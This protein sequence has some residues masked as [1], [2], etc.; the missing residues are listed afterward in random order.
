[1][2]SAQHEIL[3]CSGSAG[4]RHECQRRFAQQ[5]SSRNS[6]PTGHVRWQTCDR[7]LPWWPVND[8]CAGRFSDA[9]PC[10]RN[11]LATHCLQPKCLGTKMVWSRSCD[12]CGS[13]AL[14]HFS[15]PTGAVALASSSVCANQ[16]WAL[17]PHLAMQFHIEMDRTKLQAWASDPDP[18]WAWACDR[19]ASAQTSDQI[20]A[21]ETKY[22][23]QHQ[24][25]ADC[26]YQ[27]WL[28]P[29]VW[30]SNCNKY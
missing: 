25:M 5:S 23:T 18:D 14:R 24:R 10:A 12:H 20:L 7:S 29:T 4:R 8:S 21:G 17:G 15:V 30:Y 19:F 16:A 13:M 1:M 3:C 22:L 28:A 11:W 2:V 9:S 26:V 6:N 27:C